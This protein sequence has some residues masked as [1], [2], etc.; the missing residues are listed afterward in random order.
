MGVETHVL[1]LLML[2]AFAAGW[3]DAVAGGGGLIQLPSILAGGI[4]LPPAAGVN[5]VSSITG[6]TGA[7]IRYAR[8]GH[9]HWADVPLCGVLALAGSALGAWRLVEFRDACD[10]LTPLFA[11]CFVALAIHQVLRVWKP[12]PPVPRRRPALGYALM[13]G[14]G[15][16][17]GFIGPGAGMFLFWTFTTCFALS[18]LDGTGTTKAVNVFTNAGALVPLLL[19][20]QVLWPVALAMAAANL[21]GGQIGALAPIP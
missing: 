20:G 15:L 17:D 11:A 5:K 9:V 14:I 6:T 10:R 7:L 2:A 4:C 8:A 21:T 19:A 12:R 13:F 1:L 18:P 16:Y 3:V